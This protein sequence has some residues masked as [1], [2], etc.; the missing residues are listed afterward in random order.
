MISTRPCVNEFGR[1]P[2]GFLHVALARVTRTG[3]D[4]DVAISEG[5]DM[6]NLR[7]LVDEADGLYSARKD[8]ML[9]LKYYA[10]SIAHL[11]PG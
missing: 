6:L 11:L 8:E 9:V 7:H 1:G 4:Q 10:N 2:Q 5:L 3:R